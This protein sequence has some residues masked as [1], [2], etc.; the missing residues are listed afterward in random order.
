MEVAT[1]E[2]KIQKRQKCQKLILIFSIIT[3]LGVIAVATIR[4]FYLDGISITPLHLLLILIT[5]FLAACLYNLTF[6][7]EVK[8]DKVT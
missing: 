4:S 3:G 7:V 1:P 2:Q 8:R 5:G 6:T